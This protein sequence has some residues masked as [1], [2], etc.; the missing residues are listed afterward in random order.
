MLCLD[1]AVIEKPCCPSI[2]MCLVFYVY[3]R[4]VIL[5]SVPLY[6]TLMSTCIHGI[7]IR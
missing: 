2:A 1:N 6:K 4:N 5:R 7:D 3:Q